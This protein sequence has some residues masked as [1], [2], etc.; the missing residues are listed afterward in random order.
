MAESRCVQRGGAGGLQCS[1]EAKREDTQNVS[2]LLAISRQTHF[3]KPDRSAHAAQTLFD[4]SSLRKK[5]VQAGGGAG[6]GSRLP[7]LYSGTLR[8]DTCVE[9]IARLYGKKICER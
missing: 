2:S 5:V 8:I 7:G 9:M 3:S 6:N 4:V 1:A